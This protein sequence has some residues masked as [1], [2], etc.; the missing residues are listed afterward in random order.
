MLRSVG[1]T[2]RAS[3]ITRAALRDVEP[4]HTSGEPL[5]PA[6]CRAHAPSTRGRIRER[7]DRPTA[8]VGSRRPTGFD[9]PGPLV[10]EVRPIRRPFAPVLPEPLNLRR[11]SGRIVTALTDR[12]CVVGC[13]V[14]QARGHRVSVSAESRPDNGQCPVSVD[15]MAR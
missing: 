10:R 11:R 13:D 3:W 4:A 8:L 15:P 1:S 12:P 14:R 2:E 9:T 6:S 7:F 5:K